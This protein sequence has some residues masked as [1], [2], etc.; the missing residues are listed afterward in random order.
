MCVCVRVCMRACV[1]VCVHTY[2]VGDRQ[3][4]NLK[5]TKVTEFYQNHQT[6]WSPPFDLSSSNREVGKVFFEEVL[7]S[8]HTEVVDVLVPVKTA[9]VKV[10]LLLVLLRHDREELVMV[11]MRPLWTEEREGRRN[12]WYIMK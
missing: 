3:F 8:T 9:D 2:M 12:E 7:F 11:G 10:K 4:M 5:V 6:K 1:R